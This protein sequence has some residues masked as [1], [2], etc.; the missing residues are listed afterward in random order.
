[1]NR[2]ALIFTLFS[3]NLLTATTNAQVNGRMVQRSETSV[4]L[5]W[6]H[7]QTPANRYRV[8]F[9]DTSGTQVPAPANNQNPQTVIAAG[10]P[11]KGGL[12]TCKSFDIL[13][14]Q[15]AYRA[16]ITATG[17]GGQS[18]EIFV[19]PFGSDN[20]GGLDPLAQ[21]IA[22]KASMVSA[23]AEMVRSQGDYQKSFSESA[24]NYS[25]A[26]I[27]LAKAR[28]SHAEAFDKE[29]DNWKKQVDIYFQRREANIRGKMRVKTAQNESADLDLQLRDAK[30]KR[31]Y[32]YASRHAGTSGGRL[33]NLNAML[34]LF[35]G[36]SIGY[37][38]ALEEVLELDE[39]TD[40][41]N[42]SEDL[43]RRLKV[44][45]SSGIEFHLGQPGPINTNWPRYL[46]TTDF[47]KERQ[48]IDELVG[49]LA[50]ASD[51]RKQKEIIDSLDDLLGEITLSFLKSYG[52]GKD[53]RGWGNDAIL[54][55][56]RAD[57]FLY[58]RKREIRTFRDNP[59]AAVNHFRSFDPVH[60]GKDVG[61]LIAWMNGSGS[62]FA[63]PDPG[64]DE[65]YQ[66]VFRK[67]QEVYKLVGEPIMD[68][69]TV[70]QGIE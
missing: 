10:R 29:L 22:S 8:R 18:I 48:E 27:N 60:H 55:Y 38:Y 20:A 63:K 41:W 62:E 19:P 70:E 50:K 26:Y 14:P 61:S 51:L 12:V 23:Q 58:R 3:S 11:L 31:R 16:E 42:L 43:L 33:A 56:V 49:S 68:V 36:T 35:V 54:D 34:D 1:M 57:E 53:K 24:V 52:D 30:A 39:K 25:Q 40:Q 15:T 44:K 17:G 13:R 7:G 37:G 64:D 6:Q 28:Q 47:D 5:E 9:I 21:R 66:N 69:P 45:N 2:V 32:E 46:Q 67:M 4:T 59:R 65:A